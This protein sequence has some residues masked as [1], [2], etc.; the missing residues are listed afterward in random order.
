M[1]SATRN[2]LG[3]FKAGNP[4]KPKGATH[5]TTRKLRE[6]IVSFLN[7]KADVIPQIWDELE[8]KEQATLFLHLSKLVMP[9]NTKEA[10]PEKEFLAPVIVMPNPEKNLSEKV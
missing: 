8:P 4:G 9:S 1:S 6:T 3:H 7:E 5:K 10:E 2:K